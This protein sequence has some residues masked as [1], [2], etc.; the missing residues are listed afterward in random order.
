MTVITTRL[1]VA[2]D[3][4]IATAAPLPAGEYIAHMETREP[5][6][7]QLPAEPLDVDSLPTLDLGPWP[8][9]GRRHRG[10]CLRWWRCRRYLPPRRRRR[11]KSSTISMPVA[12]VTS[13]VLETVHGMTLEL[14]AAWPRMAA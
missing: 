3:G 2:P 1:T 12:A 8:E 9:G 11:R 6:A 7:R 10:F 5:P 4:A 13:T 14:V